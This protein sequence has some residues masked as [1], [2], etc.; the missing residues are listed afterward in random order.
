MLNQALFEE[1]HIGRMFMKIA[2]PGAI[3]MLASAIYQFIDGI[4]VNLFLG[5]TAFAAL[6]FC[7]PIIIMIFAV[8]DLIG[9]GSSVIIAIRMGQKRNKEANSIFTASL[10]LIFIAD[11]IIGLVTFFIS[12]NI[13]SLMG[14]EGN[15]LDLSTSYLQVYAITLPLTGYI[16]SL[17]NYL[18]ISGKIKTS[19]FINL[20]M[21]L[22]IV[23]IESLF[24]GVFKL[25]LWGAALASCLGF[26]IFAI[27]SFLPFLSKKSVLRLGKPHF[28][29]AEEISILKNGLSAFLNNIASRVTSLIFNIILLAEGG[30]DAVSAYGVLMYIDGFIQP[31]IYGM[32]D[33]LQPCIGYNYGSKKYDRVRKIGKISFL[34]CFLICLIG[35]IIIISI[36]G[37]LSLVFI[38]NGS[39][40][41][42][43]LSKFAL[44]VFSFTYLTRWI[45][46]ASQGIFSAIE[47][48]VPAIMISLGISFVFP[49]ILIPC[50]A[51][52]NLLGIWLNFPITSLLTGSLCIFLVY[53]YVYRRKILCDQSDKTSEA[54][55]SEENPTIDN[56][57]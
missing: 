23:G 56:L 41:L 2:I 16:F 52:L 17:D 33:S 34:T 48:P 46:Y 11:L 4:F 22:S 19:M 57:N 55:T 9:V 38:S 10:I 53:I 30:E 39:N 36:P 7:F 45:S 6:N 49:L 13:L 12:R 26:S 42:K 18:R 21:S 27:I 15:L 35:F 32:S 54:S 5:S 8:S 29:F 47:K 24:L 20:F 3:G 1:K 44:F 28:D 43:D 51:Q 14:A 37:P 40:H 25:T 50:F 31:I